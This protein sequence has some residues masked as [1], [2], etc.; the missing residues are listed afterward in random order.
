MTAERT[1][2]TFRS[3]EAEAASVFVSPSIRST[4]FQNASCQRWQREAK[5]SWHAGWS[6]LQSALLFQGAG[7]VEPAATPHAQAALEVKQTGEHQQRH[8]ARE[9]LASGGLTPKS[10]A[11]DSAGAAARTC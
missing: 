4:G 2:S 9:E 3:K 5:S 8:I 1:P 7:D 6:V 11:A 10:S